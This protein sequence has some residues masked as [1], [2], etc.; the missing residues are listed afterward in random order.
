MQYFKMYDHFFL[1]YNSIFNSPSIFLI[2]M[3]YRHLNYELSAKL[4]AISIG[5]VR[6]FTHDCSVHLNASVERA[7]LRLIARATF[8]SRHGEPRDFA[9]PASRIVPV[10]LGRTNGVD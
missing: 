10:C 8:K 9:N 6:R 1:L 5:R 3:S 7:Y 2:V 4:F